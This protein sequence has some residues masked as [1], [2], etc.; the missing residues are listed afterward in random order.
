MAEHR[1][2]DAVTT[3]RIYVSSRTLCQRTECLQTR[4]SPYTDIRVAIEAQGD[5]RKAR[6]VAILF[7]TPTSRQAPCRYRSS[8]PNVAVEALRLWGLLRYHQANGIRPLSDNPCACT[9]RVT[10][11]GRSRSRRGAVPVVDAM[12]SALKTWQ[13]KLPGPPH[14]AAYLV[15]SPWRR[16]HSITCFPRWDWSR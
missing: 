12:A 15:T 5:C 3:G 16:I 1:K 6:A 13:W 7:A 8:G 2:R 9:W 14:R 10:C 4:G 11:L